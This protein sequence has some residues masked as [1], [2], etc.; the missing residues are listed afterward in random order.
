MIEKV[1]AHSNIPIFCWGHDPIWGAY[2]FK[3]VGWTTNKIR[4]IANTYFSQQWQNLS[5]LSRLH[6]IYLLN[7][8]DIY[9]YDLYLRLTS[10]CFPLTGCMS[11][12]PPPAPYYIARVFLFIGWKKVFFPGLDPGVGKASRKQLKLQMG[13]KSKS[14]KLTD[15]WWF[16]ISNMF[17]FHP[18]FGKIFQFDDF[19]DDCWNDQ[20][21]FLDNSEHRCSKLPHFFGGWR[22][23]FV[24]VFEARKE[25]ISREASRVSRVS[26]E[27]AV[28]WQMVWLGQKRDNL[29]VFSLTFGGERSACGVFFMFL[30]GFFFGFWKNTLGSFNFVWW[31]MVSISLWFYSFRLS[32]GRVKC[33]EQDEQISSP[34][35]D[36]KFK[37]PA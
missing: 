10:T 11:Q 18:Y 13:L 14:H 36:P 31:Q 4:Y 28:W 9:V 16:Q 27:G 12:Q 1:V 22:F 24:G 37:I 26:L 32:L 17:F 21:G 7:R 3:W 33:F 19:S 23:F 35:K 8:M 5:L 29:E 15:R 30:Y 25:E 20:L 2:F 34:I 6:L